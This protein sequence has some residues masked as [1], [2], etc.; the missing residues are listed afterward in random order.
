MFSVKMQAIYRRWLILGVLSMCL[1]V[2]GFSD[3]T[4]NA[5]AAAAPCIQDCESFEK[6]C[7]DD[8]QSDCSLGSTDAAC[9]NCNLNCRQDFWDCAEHAIWCTSG[10]VSYSSECQAQ[11]GIHCI[12]IGGVY[13]CSPSAGAHNGY[14][15]VC[16]RIGYENGCIVCPGEPDEDCHGGSSPGTTPQCL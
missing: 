5:S 6:A 2:F 9:N 13:D 8:C 11:Y 16:N 3:I 12:D 14:S 10:T 1:V 15:L 4:E 7:V